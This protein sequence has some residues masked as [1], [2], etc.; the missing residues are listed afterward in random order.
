[1]VFPKMTLHHKE[2]HRAMACYRFGFRNENH[3]ES[4][5][6]EREKQASDLHQ[7]KGKFN[8]V[9]AI[10]TLLEDAG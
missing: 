3:G 6:H 7:T 2:E 5:S 8:V 1:M 10:G 4:R 9:W